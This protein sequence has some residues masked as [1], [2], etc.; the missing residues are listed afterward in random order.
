MWRTR[1]KLAEAKFFLSKLNEHRYD[2]LNEAICNPTGLELVSYFLSAFVSAARSVTWIMRSEYGRLPQWESWWKSQIPVAHVAKLLRLFN[3]LRNRSQ[4]AEPVRLGR[5]L[6]IE[7]DMGPPVE[8]DPRLPK[9]RVT[10]SA[11][12]DEAQ[13]PTF[14]GDL[15][16]FTLTVDDLEG[17]D[18]LRSC[19]DY[20]EELEKLVAACEAQFGDQM[21]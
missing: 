12:D 20:V 5:Y 2:S 8:R 18:L 10:I 6:R 4:K 19:Q 16:A 13:N 11:A 17:G 21:K 14:S 3:T 7:G 15:L 1:Q 9:L